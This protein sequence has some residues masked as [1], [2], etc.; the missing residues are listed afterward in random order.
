[1]LAKGYYFSDVTLVVLLD[2]DGALFFVDFRSVERF[3]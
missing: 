2:V 1:M 3:V